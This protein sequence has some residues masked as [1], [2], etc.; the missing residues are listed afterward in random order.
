MSISSLHLQDLI[1]SCME[2]VHQTVRA[3]FH[4]P[5]KQDSPK[6]E[7]PTTPT[8]VRDINIMAVDQQQAPLVY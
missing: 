3:C 8:D 4:T 1:R 7:Q 6:Q 2:Q 5:T